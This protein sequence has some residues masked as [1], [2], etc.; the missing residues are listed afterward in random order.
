MSLS[1][2]ILGSL[3]AAA[4]TLSAC[5]SASDNEVSATKLARGILLPQKAPPPPTAQQIGLAAA[6]VLAGT[7]EPV[8]LVSIPKIN[9]TT[10]MQRIETNG[11]YST[12]ATGDRRTITLRGGMITATRGLG[13]DVMSST[14]DDL[15]TL[16]TERRAGEAQRYMRYL[17][18][19]DIIEPIQ[20]GCVVS[21]EGS[22]Q[23]V[24]GEINSPVTTV[25]EYCRWKQTDFVNS[26]QVSNAGR[27]L[28]SRQWLSERNEYVI[29]QQ[30]R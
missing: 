6:A 13:N 23:M 10:V 29:V 21:V 17:D 16:I 12:F 1:P 4:L 5:S 7:S 30:L 8:I 2:R 14:L 3:C 11:A 28:Q 26:Y 15:Q 27:I 19:E 25:K 20:T 18:G 9:A 24:I 22:S